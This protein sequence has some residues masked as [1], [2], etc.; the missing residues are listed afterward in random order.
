MHGNPICSR[1]ALGI[2]LA[3]LAT[4]AHSANPA[5]SDPQKTDADFPFQGEYVGDITHDGQAVRFGVQV[6]AMGDRKF[7]AVAYPGGL[8]GDGWTPPNTITG[9]GSR[10][11]EGKD[12]R[13]KLTGVDWGGVTR[14]AEIRDGAIVV[15]S[16]SGTEIAKLSRVNR[17]SPT[18]GQAPP[19]TPWYSSTAWP[20]PPRP[21]RP[22]SSMVAWPTMAC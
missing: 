22:N 8:P 17:K 6:V 11:G 21:T 3:L 13:V 2:L 16:D 19:R 20:P 7:M 10:E 15:V 1:F 9:G 4:L 12:A 14:Q 5:S 18:L